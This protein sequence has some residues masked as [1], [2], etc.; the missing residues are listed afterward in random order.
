ML[1]D[2]GGFYLFLSSSQINKVPAETQIGIAIKFSRGI[3]IKV[4][5]TR[6]KP[7]VVGKPVITNCNFFLNFN[8][9]LSKTAS[10]KYKQTIVVVKSKLPITEN[11]LPKAGIKLLKNKGI[12][13][14]IINPN[15]FNSNK[16]A[17]P[18]SL[19]QEFLS[20]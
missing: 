12:V 15:F 11:R 14:T 9:L 17:R 1:K 8:L 6:P 16:I 7:K 10:K 4:K 3:L 18:I 19:I 20:Y 5:Q 13:T 2:R